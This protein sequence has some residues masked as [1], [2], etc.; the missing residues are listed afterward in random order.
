MREA[1]QMIPALADM[2]GRVVQEFSRAARAVGGPSLL[3]AALC[4]AAR[5]LG[6]HHVLLQGACGAVWLAD[7][8]P[9]WRTAPTPDED[10]VLTAAAQSLVPFLWSDIPRLVTP[11]AGRRDFLEGAV[12]AGVGAAM[13][14]PV[15][16]ICGPKGSGGYSVFAGCCTFAMKNGACLPLEGLAAAHHVGAL[17]LDA[18]ERLC[19]DAPAPAPATMPSLTP[20]QRDCVVLV[21]QGK[22]DW[23]IGQLLGIS[24]STVHK[25]IEDAK[26]RFGV[27]TRIQL[28]VRS[29]FDARLTFADVMK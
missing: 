20:R 21:A 24:E 28:V 26:R 1:P 12:A 2:R 6:F 16:R 9:T 29:L 18:A 5:A 13:T 25:H 8:P 14:V 23:E 17:A 7:M 22:S 19:G 11:T 15:H 10:A 3:R 4:D 27:S